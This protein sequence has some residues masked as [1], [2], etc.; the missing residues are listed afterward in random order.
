MTPHTLSDWLDYQ[1]RI[2]PR[3]IELGLDRVR[4]AWHAL[5]ARRPA[6]IVITVGGTNGKG[7][8]V[9]MLEAMLRA[10]GR[11]VAAYTSPHLVRYNER[12]RINGVEPI[13]AAWMAVFERIERARGTI[14]LTY[15]EFGTLAALELAADAGVDVAL[16]EVGLGGRLDAVN[17]VDADV[18]IVVSIGID[19]T[20]YLG[21]DRDSIGR[22]KAGIFR[23]GHAAI[24][25]DRDPPAGLLEG[26]ERIGACVLRAGRDFGIT[27]DDARVLTALPGSR[28][29]SHGD[30]D[31]LLWQCRGT[32][33]ELDAAVLDAPGRIDNAACAL[34]ALHALRGVLGWPE[35][36]YARGLASTRLPARVQR[37]PGPPEII[38]DVAHNP[39][40]ARALVGWLDRHPPAGRTL[41]VFSALVD[42]DVAA[43]GAILGP[44]IARWHLCAL[45][46]AGARSLDAAEVLRRL[47]G[48]WSALNADCHADPAAA[49]AAALGEAAHDDRILAFGSFHLAGSV[50][51]AMRQV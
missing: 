31:R 51:A 6:P 25:G 9:A 36:E 45:A 42:K 7:T 15:F 2:H 20:E 37:I 14:P 5:G 22:E 40:A 34:A 3:G 44:R 13:D 12:L 41:A 28:A 29:A 30:G 46:D 19:H 39:H 23:A 35:R 1:Q 32:T 26:A 24:I 16:L 50:L 47:R 43:I 48:G 49:L 27:A 38:V 17:I 33:I 11:R 10:T 18:A 21:A 4:A 8:T